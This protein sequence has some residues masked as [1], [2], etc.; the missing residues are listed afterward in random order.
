MSR[1]E[2]RAFFARVEALDMRE[3]L[4]DP[5]QAKKLLADLGA[6]LFPDGDT[7]LTYMTWAERI[8]GAADRGSAA[9]AAARD[10][11][12]GAE[13]RLRAAESRYRTLVEQIPAVT[14]MAALGEGQNEIYVSPHIE[15]MLG[16]T[17]QEWLENPFLWY[18]QLHPDD[19]AMWNEEFARGCRTGGPFRAECRFLARDGRIVWVHGEARLVKDDRGRPQFLQGIAFDIT[20]SKRAHEILVHDA[21]RTAKTQEELAIARRVQTSILPRDLQ[22]DGLEIAAA[23]IPASEVGGDYY[24]VIRRPDGCWLAIGDVTGHGLDAGLVMLMVQSALGSLV[25]A[26]PAA[27]PR[28]V[29]CALNEVLFDNIRS[30]LEHDDHVT[31]SL[32]RYSRDGRLA[33]AG[34]HEDI[35]LWHAREARL[36]TIATPGTWLGARADISHAI[37]DTEIRLEDG[38]LLVLYTDGITEAKSPSGELYDLDR[39]CA[40]VEAVHDRSPEQVR[41]HILA[42]IR[43]WMASQDDDITVLV[44]RYHAQQTPSPTPPAQRRE[45]PR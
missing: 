14:F 38:D 16:F 37:V 9:S 22:V 18:W 32:L 40:A 35:L 26:M 5:E 2:Q 41:D 12:A 6:G 4:G 1:E 27:S 20:E 19:R 28:D 15:A 44:L 36:E 39:L 17:Q 42:E 34:A 7:D 8:L 23:M 10:T 13:E 29:V 24:D 33:F 45:E 21:V 25:R 3:V 43:A 31:F 30:R 11:P